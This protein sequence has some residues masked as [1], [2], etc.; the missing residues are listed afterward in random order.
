MVFDTS[1]K[2]AAAQ[3]QEDVRENRPQHAGL[4]DSNFSI[5]Q[6][7]NAD[8]ILLDSSI[9]RAQPT[10]NQLHSIAKCRIQ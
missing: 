5:L 2:K 9:F 8:L 10:Y 3:Y 1:R 7:D 4:N 6:R